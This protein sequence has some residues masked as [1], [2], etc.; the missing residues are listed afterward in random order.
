[1]KR[2]KIYNKRS[3]DLMKRLFEKQGL[4]EINLAV[5]ESGADCAEDEEVEE[6][7]YE[8]AKEVDEG[9]FGNMGHQEEEPQGNDNPSQD[10][11][12]M[13]DKHLQSIRGVMETVNALDGDEN[14]IKSDFVGLLQ[15][16][17]AAVLQITDK[18]DAN[19]EMGTEPPMAEKLRESKR[20]I[21]LKINSKKKK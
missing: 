15:E 18:M 5:R 6:E 11:Y 19:P 4:G 20:S 8:E 16:F 14:F 21:K 12:T 9:G 13:V 7:V 10:V 17:E 3:E 2:H 1:M